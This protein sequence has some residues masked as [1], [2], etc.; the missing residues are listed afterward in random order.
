MTVKELKKS[1]RN[2]KGFKFYD[3][4]G[5]DISNMPPIILDIM[6]VIGSGYNADGTI[7]VDVLYV[8]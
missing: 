3:V 1:N 2:A 7:D 6:K 8:K 4:N 5:E